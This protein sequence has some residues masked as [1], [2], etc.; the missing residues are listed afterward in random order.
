MPEDDASSRFLLLSVPPGPVPAGGF[1]LVLLIPD[2]DGPGPRT[3]TYAARLL[4]NG[5]VVAE[6]Y[7][8]HDAL[9]TFLPDL[10]ATI[11]SDARLDAGRIAAVALGAGARMA[12]REWASGVPVAALAL[13]Y[14]GCDT[15]LVEV[16]RHATPATPGTAMLLL[17]GATDDA[18]PQEACAALADALSGA[19]RPIHHVLPGATYAWD[20][21]HL[22]AAGAALRALHP[23]APDGPRVLARPDAAATLVAAD[24]VITFLTA[25]PR[26]A[27]R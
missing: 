14:P 6:A 27:S 8:G 21:T 19:A 5:F 26:Q 23:A 18:N 16:A 1:P 11:A 24:R 9:G 13:L 25:M 17:H 7:L 22:V 2:A 15:E 12:L 10:M 3:E 4:A 20:A